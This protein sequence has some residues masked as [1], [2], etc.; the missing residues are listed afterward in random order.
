MRSGRDFKKLKESVGNAWE[1]NYRPPAVCTE[2]LAQVVIKEYSSKKAGLKLVCNES[3]A[4][5]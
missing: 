4:N 1:K 2:H 3:H 5:N